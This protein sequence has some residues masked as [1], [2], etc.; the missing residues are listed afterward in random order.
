[1]VGAHEPLDTFEEDLEEG[2]DHYNAE[3]EDAERLEAPA[4]DGVAVAVLAGA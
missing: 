2:G 4:A 3:D 1:M